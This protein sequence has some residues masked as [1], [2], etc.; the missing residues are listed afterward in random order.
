[1]SDVI[2][3]IKSAVMA[4]GCSNNAPL[5]YGFQSWTSAHGRKRVAM[6]FTAA[7]PRYGWQKLDYSEIHLSEVFAGKLFADA[8]YFQYLLAVRI[9]TTVFAPRANIILLNYEIQREL[10]MRCSHHNSA[11]YKRYSWNSNFLQAVSVVLRSVQTNIVV[12]YK[13]LSHDCVAL[14]CPLE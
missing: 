9:I 5:F 10:Y 1:M 8:R 2:M 6:R 12:N 14:L 7:R 13:H 3:H 4:T 11:N